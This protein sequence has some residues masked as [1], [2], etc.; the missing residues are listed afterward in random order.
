MQDVAACLPASCCR[1]CTGHR[2]VHRLDAEGP[3]YGEGPR[4]AI[5]LVHN[6][7]DESSG[8]QVAVVLGE[9]EGREIARD[10]V[11]LL[12][13]TGDLAPSFALRVQGNSGKYGNLGTCSV[14]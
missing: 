4:G 2:P 11:P 3:N 13:F 12:G 7:V 8:S 9:A 1:S 5:A 6:T 10:A 14:M